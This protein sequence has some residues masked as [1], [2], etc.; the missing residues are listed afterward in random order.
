MISSS[1]KTPANLRFDRQ[2]LYV[3]PSFSFFQ[4][5]S[6]HGADITKTDHRGTTIIH[7]CCTIQDANF[8]KS[9]LSFGRTL[10][11]RLSTHSA[12]SVAHTATP[13]GTALQMGDGEGAT[14]VIVACQNGNLEQLTLLVEA[15]VST[16][17][18]RL[19]LLLIS[20]NRI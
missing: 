13:L 20:L 2:R 3:C 14:P 1:F 10:P 17:L 6:R 9:V 8:L 12:L 5:M 11:R 19:T 18:I 7:R 16:S 4:S 15:G